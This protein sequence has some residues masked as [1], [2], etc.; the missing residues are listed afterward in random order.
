MTEQETLQYV[1]T[2][3]HAIDLTLDAAQAQRVAAHLQRTFGIVAGLK[4]LTMPP[5]QELAEIYRP[6]PWPREED[7][8][9]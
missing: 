1:N 8:A 2:T 9:S 4:A 6:A 3:A 5:D 7:D